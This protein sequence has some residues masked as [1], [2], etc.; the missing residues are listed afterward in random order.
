MVWTHMRT[1][2]GGCVWLV[3]RVSPAG[4]TSIHIAVTLEYE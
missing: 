4:C 2:C 3:G 1:E